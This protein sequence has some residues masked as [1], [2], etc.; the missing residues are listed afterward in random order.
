MQGLKSVAILFLA[1]ITVLTG[2]NE[3]VIQSVY[4]HS[5]L[6]IDAELNE[7]DARYFTSLIEKKIAI[8]TMN[9]S[10]NLYLAVRCVDPEL[11]RVIEQSGI[12]IWL[13][14]DDN[15]SKDFEFHYPAS[16]YSVVNQTRGGFWQA[17]TD[18][19]KQ[20]A[21]KKLMNMGS[22]ILVI[23]KREIN[24][25]VFSPDSNRS[26]L[27][28]TTESNGILLFEIRI[29]LHIENIFPKFI[30]LSEKDRISLGFGF[31]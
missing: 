21:S 24:S 3:K 13:D 26:F 12:T 4:V 27:A 7:W 28:A 20:R 17:M 1:M 23:D 5:P 8:S 30:S 31:S 6:R 18:S 14:P 9:D 29:P 10:I 19:Q 16:R 11:I 25:H 22:G 15:Q 2:C